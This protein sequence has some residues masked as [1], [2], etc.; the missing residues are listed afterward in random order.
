MST[1]AKLPGSLAGTP[2]L[3]RWL[4]VE[5]DGTVTAFTGKV[6]IGQ[7]ILTALTQIVA[8]ELDVPVARVRLVNADTATSPD[9]GVTSGSRSIEESGAALRVAS[10]QARELLLA[11]AAKRLA[12]SLED[13][14]VRDGIVHAKSGA[15]VGYG[16]LA[17]AVSFARAVDAGVALKPASEHRVIGAGV[18]RI[19]LAAKVCGVPV[20]LQD[21]ELPGMLHGRVAR[22]PSY[23]AELTAFDEAAVKAAAGVAAVI[24]DGRFLAVACEREDQAVRAQRALA[25]AATWREKPM[26]PEG[27]AAGRHLLGMPATEQVVSEKTDAAAQ[28]RGKQKLKATYTR[29]FIAHASIGPSCAMARCDAGRYTVW[30]HSQSI[31]LLRRDLAA[32]LRTEESSITVIH[33]PGAGCYGH[34]GADDVALDA[35]LVARAVPGRPVKLQWM[36]EDEFA[37]EPYGSAMLVELSAALDEQGSIVEWQADHWSHPHSNRPGGKGGQN[38]LAGWHLEDPVPAAAPGDPPL[39]AGG[40]HRNAAPLYRFAHE[41]VTNHLVREMPVRVS[42]LRSLGA[43]ANI[44]AIESFM[45]ELAAA[46]GADPVEFRLRHL[47]DP[48]ARAVIETVARVSGWDERPRD[49][50]GRGYGIGFARYK[51]LGSYVAV[52]AEVELG[53]DVRMTRG[54][55][56]VD[57]GL[58]INPDGVINQI[59]GGIIQAASWTLKEQVTYDGTRILARTWDD[60]PVLKFSEAPELTVMIVERRDRPPVGAGE[61]AQGPTAAAIANAIFAAS[62]ARVRDMPLTRDRI[63]AA[64]A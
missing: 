31:F 55:A 1:P 38:L 42:A 20:Y 47:E 16:E 25:R 57:V 49:A 4:R 60:Y 17:G 62:G 24:R 12:C 61:G 52:V 30:S 51:N 14:T 64:M 2:R 3:D 48:R 33:A 29:P 27:V 11:E 50:D 23:A 28:A 8:E 32:A 13:L 21:M 44:F 37:W 58:A 54:W 9:E 19:E 35:A 5:P 53:E 45:D 22:P 46:A 15:T 39:P 59:E 56:A 26:L 40:S 18:P 36:R 34:N 63:V 6:E 43:H 7:G 41:R 10:A